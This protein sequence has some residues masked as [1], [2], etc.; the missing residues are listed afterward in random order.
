MERSRLTPRQSRHRDLPS[1]FSSIPICFLQFLFACHTVPLYIPSPLTNKTTP[2]V[3]ITSPDADLNSDARDYFVR[4]MRI[5][6][7]VTPSFPMPE[8]HEQIN[9]LRLAFS[10]DINKPFELKASFPLGSPTTGSHQSHPSPPSV[11]DSYSGRLYSGSGLEQQQH[12]QQPGQ[13]IQQQQQ[14]Q[15]QHQHPGHPI[16]PPISAHDLDPKTDSPL[17]QPLALL[18]HDPEQSSSH[19]QVQ[20][21]PSRIFA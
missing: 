13:H 14:Q 18:G 19:L 2:Q 20:W 10:A 15:Q 1:P 17:V 4:H 16:T 6:E 3:A 5:L 21:N 9:A 12:Q 7:Q 11:E 8:M